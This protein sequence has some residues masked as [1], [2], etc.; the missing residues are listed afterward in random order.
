MSKELMEQV[1]KYTEEDRKNIITGTVN[2]LFNYMT[3]QLEFDQQKAFQFIIYMLGTFTSINGGIT[4]EQYELFQASTGYKPSY[5]EVAKFYEGYIEES[6]KVNLHDTLKTYEAEIA[7]NAILFGYV[8]MSLKGSFTEEEAAYLDYLEADENPESDEY[9]I[10][11]EDGDYSEL[12]QNTISEDELDITHETL[13]IQNELMSYSREKRG[14]IAKGSANAIYKALEVAGIE[15]DDIG[16]LIYYLSIWTA[17]VDYEGGKDNTYEF[18][19]QNLMNVDYDRFMKEADEKISIE[20]NEKYLG[21][22]AMAECQKHARV[23]VMALASLDGI[24]S[25]D[26]LK[27]ADLIYS[28]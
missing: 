16:S 26:A 7:A 22:I 12:F 8:M 14:N 3:K 25:F 5:E 4:K 24:I 23:Y 19:T 15:R 17:H 1:V 2:Q 6:D 13:E 9:D 20:N 10:D 11:D 27:L 21:M 28:A 18:L